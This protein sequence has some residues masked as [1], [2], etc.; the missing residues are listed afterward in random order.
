MRERRR[1]RDSEVASP[2]LC[3]LRIFRRSFY[4]TEAYQIGTS[5]GDLQFDDRAA[6]PR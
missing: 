6:A 1:E 2:F 5:K 3:E 4:E